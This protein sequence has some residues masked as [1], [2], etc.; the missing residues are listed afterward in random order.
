[1]L[2]KTRR[3]FERQ[4][5]AFAAGGA[6]GTERSLVTEGRVHKFEIVLWFQLKVKTVT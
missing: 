2:Q 4:A 1:M 5:A 3:Q 6:K